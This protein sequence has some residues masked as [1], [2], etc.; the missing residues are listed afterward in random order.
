MFELVLSMRFLLESREIILKKV[1]CFSF[2]IFDVPFA[3]WL[4]S[5]QL[6]MVTMFFFITPN[7]TKHDNIMMAHD[8]NISP[9]MTTSHLILGKNTK[10]VA[11]D[12]SYAFHNYM[13]LITHK[14]LL[15]AKRIHQSKALKSRHVILTLT[16]NTFTVMP[17][18]FIQLS[19]CNN[20]NPR[21]Y[22]FRSNK[23]QVPG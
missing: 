22:F 15:M 2:F 16:L 6:V 17:N 23:R 12:W 5:G 20:Y 11:C 3:L 10:I 21:M 19:I 13:S 14:Q 9:Y 18:T 7:V 4:V 1:H 8:D